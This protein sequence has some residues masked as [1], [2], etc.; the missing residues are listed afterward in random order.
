[1]NRTNLPLSEAMNYINEGDILL[2][3][4][5]G[6][7]SRWIQRGGEGLY[8]HVGLASWHCKEGCTSS[9]P[10]LEITEFREWKG[11]RTTNLAV[12]YQ[13]HIRKGLIDV[14]RVPSFYYT[15]RFNP[16]VKKV[17]E[18]EVN[19]DGRRVTD[20]MRAMTGLPYGWSR[21][22]WL[23]KYK[24]PVIRLFLGSS[25]IS[26]DSDVDT[27]YPVCSTAVAACFS[28]EGIDLAPNMSDGWM[29]PSDISRSP[30]TN[31]L[32]TLTAD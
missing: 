21:I 8:S 24:L 6:P 30:L 1:M 22:W 23:M 14:Y 31:Y 26:N 28:K 15:L 10:I 27:F 11:G 4:G 3:R 12:A 20:H 17:E 19:F 13:D 5:E 32:F 2:F 29:E 16:F 25:I 18:Y 9:K 7:F